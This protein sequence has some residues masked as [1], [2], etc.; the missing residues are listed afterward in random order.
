MLIV[1]RHGPTQ[2]NTPGAHSERIRGHMDIPLSEPGREIARLAGANV[3][4]TLKE[5][6]EFPP[7]DEIYCSD[8]SR[9][10]E[11][12][13]IVR[14]AIKSQLQKQELTEDPDYRPW[15]LGRLTGQ[16]ISEIQP[17]IDDLVNNPDEKAPGGESLNA[18]L[19]RYYAKVSELVAEEDETCILVTHARNCSA[20]EYFARDPENTHDAGADAF[21][22]SPTSVDPGGLMI[23]RP[24]WTY[25]IINPE[26]KPQQPVNGK[27]AV[28][29]LQQ[30]ARTS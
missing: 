16:L 7:L 21:L 6:P 18:F 15:D 26:K 12:A 17:E 13:E 28:K 27:A 3:K 5:N 22:K 8:L 23:V 9:A 1:V 30:A 24:N 10:V 29:G 4:E 19:D 14:D 25:D 2:Y 20:I 11:T